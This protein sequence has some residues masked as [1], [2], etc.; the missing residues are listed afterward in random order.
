VSSRIEQVIGYS[1]RDRALLQEALTH[2]TF[3]HE[4]P[5]E[6]DYERLEHLGDAVLGLVVADHLFRDLP[7][8]KESELTTRRASVVE[9]KVLARRWVELELDDALRLGN[10]MAE[11]DPRDSARE[12][13]FEALIGAVYVDSG[14]EAA[15]R[16]VLRLL[17]ARI[18]AGPEPVVETPK[19]RLQNAIQAEGLPPPRYEQVEQVGPVHD[20]TFTFA[21]YSEGV[22]IGT[23]A[24]K[25]KRRAE[26][27][28]ARDALARRGDE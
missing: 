27:A 17:E 18:A 7:H 14:L 26:D 28:A 12:N 19:T 10:G 5:G 11:N 22:L 21:V 20:P 16:V 6:R 24:G 13:A 3:A 15:R 8:A 1:F 9:G 4:H 23:G 25:S 2:P